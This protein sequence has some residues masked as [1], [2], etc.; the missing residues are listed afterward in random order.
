[1]TRAYAGAARNTKNAVESMGKILKKEKKVSPARTM[2]N[3]R[4]LVSTSLQAQLKGKKKELNFYTSVLHERPVAAE[5]K[6][7]LRSLL[8]KTRKVAGAEEYSLFLSD[9]PLFE[10]IHLRAT[11]K[12]KRVSFNKKRGIS[13]WVM[14]NGLPLKV[15]E[16][17]RDKRFSGKADAIAGLKI[18]SL[19][20]APLIIK[21]R[22]VGVLRL[23]NKKGGGPFTDDDMNLLMSAVNYAGLLV[24]RAFLYE[25]LKNDELTNLFNARHMNHVL[26]MEVERALRYN[27]MFSIVFMDIDNFK[28]IND[29]YGHLVGSRALIE[30]AWLLRDNLRRVDIIARYGGDEFVIIL[31]ETPHDESFSCAERLRKTIEKNKFL[32][33]EGISVRLTASLGVASFPDDAE[34][35][36][37]LLTMADKAMYRGKFSTKNIVFSAAKKLPVTK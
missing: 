4:E 32:K 8:E 20:C 16:V 34:T 19:I 9:E 3:S 15:N 35:K 18:A 30:V 6:K 1:M 10:K 24:E 37:E 22:T 12:I 7:S 14:D 33:Q 26:E 5:L 21:D 31:P 25:K 23:A 17:S 2:N 29:R 27:A 13:G 28:T 11:K 36:E